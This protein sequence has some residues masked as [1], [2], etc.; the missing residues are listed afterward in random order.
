M[1]ETAS[2]IFQK[3]I[4]KAKNA[5]I[6][7]VDLQFTSLLGTLKSKAVSL[8]EFLHEDVFRRGYGVDGSSVRGFGVPVEESD[9]LLIP[10]IKTFHIMP[11]IP[12][13]ARV[14]CNVCYPESNSNPKHF[15]GDPR[16]V[17]ERVSDSIYTSLE[18]E[19]PKGS[20]YEF[21]V[22]PELE[23]FLLS[24]EMKDIDQKGYFDA[25]S[26]QTRRLLNEIM[27][28]MGNMGLKFEAWHHEVAPSQY[29]FDFRYGEALEIA[30]GTVTLKD[31]IRNYADQHGIVATFM[32]KPFCGRNGSGM[33]CHLNLSRY[34]CSDDGSRVKTNLFYDE[35]RNGLSDIG[36]FF[37][38]GLLDHAPALTAITNPTCNSYK[39][40]VPGWEAPV[41]IAWG[42]KNRTALI[43]VPHGHPHATRCEYRSPDPSANP[44]L[45]FAAM[46]AAGLDGVS[47]HL[48]P[49]T[50]S[51]I[52]LYH[53]SGAGGAKN[54]P[55]SLKESL[56][57]LK[58]DSVL[59][60]VL[61]SYVIKNFIEAKHEEI[62]NYDHDQSRRP[63]K[64]LHALR[65]PTEVDFKW[66][67]N[68]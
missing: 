35:E 26:D 23:F 22:A 18:S 39:R 19:T 24:P 6:R 25:P 11:W 10:D 31:M 9:L 13:T 5:G 17:L 16:Q 50:A 32:P 33:H 54:L 48:N 37:I 57:A 34:Y 14:I 42:N 62:K 59:C 3:K 60:D 58:N 7:S 56:T 61:G 41:K 52:N 28:S 46:L 2:E 4:I 27:A 53:T 45:A 43:R 47:R 8:D 44:Y 68:V 63:Y 20:T 67:L 15:E 49:A 12:H 40:I 65:K 55:G 36:L 29:E 66:Y 30:D 64:T 38:A 21:H 1:T 51:E